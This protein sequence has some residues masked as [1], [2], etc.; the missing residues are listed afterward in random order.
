M[1]LRAC[2]VLGG[3]EK[4][5]EKKEGKVGKGFSKEEWA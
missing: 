4:G 2:K 5:G 3:D 1:S